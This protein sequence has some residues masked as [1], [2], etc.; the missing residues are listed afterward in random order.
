MKPLMRVFGS[1]AALFAALLFLTAPNRL[2]AASA[3][4]LVETPMFEDAVKEEGGTAE[5]RTRMSEELMDIAVA[6][7]FG[8]VCIEIAKTTDW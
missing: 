7:V 1:A 2:P 4:T 8:A 3:L 6:A 5:G